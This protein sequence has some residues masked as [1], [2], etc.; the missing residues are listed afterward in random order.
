M[1]VFQKNGL[2]VLSAI[3][4]IVGAVHAQDN[5]GSQD[6]PD[7]PGGTDPSGQAATVAPSPDA[8]S[9]QMRM[10]QL[11]IQQLMG[12][13]ELM[14]E[15]KGELLSDD[16][17][18]ER[19]A[20]EILIQEM[21]MDH[22]YLATMRDGLRTDTD[23]EPE[24]TVLIDKISN[25]KAKLVK[26]KDA[27]MSMTQ[28]LMVRQLAANRIAM[29]NGGRFNQDG[30]EPV[31]AETVTEQGVDADG[32]EDAETPQPAGANEPALADQPIGG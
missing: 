31:N 14:A 18:A 20:R 17:I 12:S 9:E 6:R 3:C 25:A 10:D 11:A 5:V 15:A 23:N 1:S 16:A 13:E 4:L 8:T 27:L 28:E 24:M 29:I 22:E 2:V 26:D 30:S 19:V 32:G 7:L 21:V